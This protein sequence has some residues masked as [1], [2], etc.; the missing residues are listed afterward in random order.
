M[1]KL[2]SIILAFVICITLSAPA[3]AANVVDSGTCGENLSWS[4]TSDGILTITGTGAMVN[5]PEERGGPW[6]HS[7]VPVR[8]I[9]IDEGV[10]SIGDHAFHTPWLAND[11]IT[12][13]KLPDSC[14]WV[15]D[16]AF[17]GLVLASQ[18]ILPAKM[19]YIG[20][21]A[22]S[23]CAKTTT[24]RVPNGINTLNIA[25]FGGCTD[26]TTVYL[27]S[28]IVRIERSVFHLCPNLRD[29]Y[30]DGTI[31]EWQAVSINEYRNDALLSATV[32]F[33]SN[34][35]PT[36]DTPSKWAVEEVNAALGAGIV[37][38]EAQQD[39]TKPI[40]RLKT[41]QMFITMLEQATGKSIDDFMA[42]KGVKIN[43]GVFTD[44]TDHAVLAANALGI[45]QGVAVNKFDP[46]STLTRAQAAAIVNRIANVMGI[47]TSFYTHNFTD[48]TKHWVNS[49]LGWPTQTRIIRGVATNKF[50]P[51]S[52]LTT[53]QAI[54]I[55]YRT[56]EIFK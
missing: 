53:E 21:R 27:P 31:S 19:S 23:N 35:S 32:H 15:G 47:D 37:P 30:F 50:D 51:D 2:L 17:S 22:F 43:P 20:A 55:A 25:V 4:L 34:P 11:T 40:S 13:I 29:I 52:K 36:S 44:T 56:F 10:T 16:S 38:T 6:F 45:I 46:D 41:V 26:L 14:I 18:I 48:A 5:Y 39:Y 3:F 7:S 12:S 1:K 9:N 28:D 42:E 33:N 24:I 49:E 8:E 54:V